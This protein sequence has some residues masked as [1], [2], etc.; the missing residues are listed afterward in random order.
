MPLSQTKSHPQAHSPAVNIIEVVLVVR[1]VVVDAVEVHAEATVADGHVDAGFG[2]E[3]KT[4]IGLVVGKFANVLIVDDDVAA[5]T[6][7]N[8]GLNA[9]FR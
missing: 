4:E 3:G 7:A 1:H 5:D 9:G 6:R 2:A 8:I